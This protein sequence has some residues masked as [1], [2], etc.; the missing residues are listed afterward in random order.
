MSEAKM[1]DGKIAISDREKYR[2]LSIE[3]G[4]MLSVPPTLR[5]DFEA[6]GLACKW[7]SKNKIA[8]HGGYHPTNWIPY[9]ISN[10]QKSKLS[11]A[12]LGKIVSSCLERGDLI[13]AVKP[14]ELQDKHKHNIRRKTE[15]QLQSYHEEVD[16][17]GKKILRD[18]DSAE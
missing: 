16:A 3:T 5:A 8:R 1:K 15:Q 2:A 14:V 13:L 6:A 17:K 10:E 11:N 4:D 12:F 7:V 9:E 18:T